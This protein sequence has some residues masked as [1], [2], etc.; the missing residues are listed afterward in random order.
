M[1]EERVCAIRLVR[2]YGSTIRLAMVD[3]THGHRQRAVAFLVEAFRFSPTRGV[4]WRMKGCIRE[5]NL[6]A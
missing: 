1:E 4:S 2:E 5:N 6:N 3:R